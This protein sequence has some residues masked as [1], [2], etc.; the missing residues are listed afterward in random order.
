MASFRSG[1]DRPESQ[2]DVV[3]SAA[4]VL[5]WV[6]YGVAVMIGVIAVAFRL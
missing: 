1:E 5:W 3:G 6:A 2:S 4:Y